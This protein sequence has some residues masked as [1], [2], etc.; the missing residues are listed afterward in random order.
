MK[1][2]YSTESKVNIL[3]T[4]Q[5]SNWCLSASQVCD[6]R[7]SR[8]AGSSARDDSESPRSMTSGSS[9]RSWV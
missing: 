7:V 6:T 3:L 8:L 4:N 9:P 2:S 5:Y 1:V